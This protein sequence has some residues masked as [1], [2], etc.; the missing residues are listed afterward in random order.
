MRRFVRSGQLT[1]GQNRDVRPGATGVSHKLPAVVAPDRRLCV[2]VDQCGQ[3][4]V[5][6]KH[7]V[8]ERADGV[9]LQIEVR[10]MRVLLFRFLNHWST[11]VAPGSGDI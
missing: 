10:S 5:V 7:V 1:C 3:I 8:R 11:G 2:D 6:V 9:T 4:A